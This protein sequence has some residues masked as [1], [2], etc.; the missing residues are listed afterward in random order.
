MCQYTSGV[1]GGSEDQAYQLFQQHSWHLVDLACLQIQAARLP[2]IHP[3]HST[4]KIIMHKKKFQ[5]NQDMVQQKCVT[6]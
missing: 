4:S 1:D 5:Q 2:S 6:C 3:R